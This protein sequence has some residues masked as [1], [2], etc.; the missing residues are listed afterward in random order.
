MKR[1]TYRNDIGYVLSRDG[2]TVNILVAPR[3]RPYDN[4]RRQILFDVGAAQR[5][6]CAVTVE[7]SADLRAGIV[8]CRGC[9]Y[10][11]GLLRRSFPKQMLEVVE[12]PH[13]DD[14]AFHALAGID[15]PLIRRAILTFSAQLWQKGDLVRV[16]AGEFADTTGRI[17]SVD[18]QNRSTAINIHH[19]KGS[20]EYSCPISH[21][22]HVHECGDWVKIFAGSDKGIEGCVVNHV[23]ENLVLAV[24]R[25][26]ETVEVRA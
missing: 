10:H 13:P 25:F 9:V 19:D 4:D 26:G 21:L 12:L 24:R 17:L 6:G 7:Q 2:D 15:S 5:A 16:V 22:Q 8:T 11:Q 1:G 20:V 14:L 3:E 23:G 18:M